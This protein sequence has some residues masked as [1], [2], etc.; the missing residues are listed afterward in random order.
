MGSMVL[1]IV[2][3]IL[4]FE[5]QGARTDL[6]AP[7]DYLNRVQRKHTVTFLLSDFVLLGRAALVAIVA[8]ITAS[9]TTLLV[10]PVILQ[11]AR[12]M[13]SESVRKPPTATESELK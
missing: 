9:L 5:P 1:R 7:L 13:R 3:E 2:R 10:V 12:R 6:V 11:L 8:L 4:F